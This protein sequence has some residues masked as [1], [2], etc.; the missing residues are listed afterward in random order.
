[1][2]NQEHSYPRP[3]E[4]DFIYDYVV[5]IS[6][7]LASLPDFPGM[8]ISDK[9]IQLINGFSDKGL[10]K[11]ND[12][13]MTG[14]DRDYNIIKWHHYTVS[15]TED[16]K[17]YFS[18]GDETEINSSE[19]LLKIRLYEEQIGQI[20]G[21]IE[22]EPGKTVEVNY[23]AVRVNATPFLKVYQQVYGSTGLYDTNKVEK[24]TETFVKSGLTWKIQRD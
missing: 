16:G 5:P 18:G 2:I 3:I 13:I 24:E 11:I 9:E 19:N 20:S 17:K 22:M 1:M 14:E 10:V 15:M 21:M 8:Q 4:M 6:G 23:T 12:K 7:N